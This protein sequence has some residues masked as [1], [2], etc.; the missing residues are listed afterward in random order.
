MGKESGA[1]TLNT[2]AWSIR[3]QKA[4]QEELKKKAAETVKKNKRKKQKG[5]EIAKNSLDTRR[6][7][8]IL[9][10]KGN[11]LEKKRA[12]LR[13]RAKHKGI[14]EEEEEGDENEDDVDDDGYEDDEYEDEDDEDEDDDDDD[15]EEDTEQ[16]NGKVNKGNKKKDKGKATRKMDAKDLKRIKMI[17]KALRRQEIRLAE[18]AK[19]EKDKLA[20]NLELQKD[21]LKRAHKHALGRAK[22][23]ADLADEI[24]LEE[25]NKKSK[26]RRTKGDSQKETKEE[27]RTRDNDE[28][29]R[30]SLKKYLKK[31]KLMK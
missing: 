12:R 29:D 28:Q 7:L 14:D 9:R 1:G 19:K 5:G 30:S 20:V 13:P 18:R 16:K 27:R 31:A 2:V 26:Q 4:K 23:E 22:M 11:S 21:N 3:W 8:S 6:E 15:E 17:N 24:E 25:E 10:G